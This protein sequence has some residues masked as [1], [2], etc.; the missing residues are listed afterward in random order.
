MYSYICG[1]RPV[2]KKRKKI[3]IIPHPDRRLGFASARVETEAGTVKSAWKYNQDHTITYKIE[4]PFDTEAEV[5]FPDETL[6]IEA[7]RHVIRK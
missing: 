7:G 2:N 6:H 4:I 5:I 1:I 3:Q